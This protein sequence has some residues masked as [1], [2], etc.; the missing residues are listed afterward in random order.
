[1]SAADVIAK[2][3]SQRKLLTI[4]GGGI[5]GMMAI[6]ILEE[7][8]L[9]LKE[10]LG[11]RGD[12]RLSDYFDYFAGTSTGAIIAACLSWGMSIQEVYNFYE[13]QGPAM[14]EYGRLPKLVME[15]FPIASWRS[16][17]VKLFPSPFDPANLKQILSQVFQ[18]NGKPAEFGTDNLK[19]LLMMVLRNATTDSP[20]PLSNNP[21]AKYN[22]RS[23]KDCNLKYPLWQL[24]RASTAAPTFFPPESFKINPDKDPHLFVDGGITPYNNPAFKL[25]LMATVD[26]YNLNWQTGEDKMLLVSI[27]TGTTEKADETLKAEGLNLIYNVQAIPSALMYAGQNEQDFLCRVFGRC[28]YGPELDREVDYKD[29]MLDCMKDSVGPL[30]EKLFTYVRYDSQLDKENLENLRLF[31][32]AYLKE[33][34]LAELTDKDI[35]KL[36]LMDCVEEN[37]LKNLYQIGKAIARQHMKPEHFEK[38]VPSFAIEGSR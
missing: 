3:T 17:L 6:G 35:A 4:D 38:F 26:R 23:R 16:T 8:E 18:E 19:T 13:Q 34:G 21:N 20:W 12:F 24:I 10:K 25:F 11:E 31:D 7:L 14:F 2:E 33:I 28:L 36:Q 37:N 29:K 30:Q 1:M 27:G 22:Q 32:K 15:K 5:R 9:H